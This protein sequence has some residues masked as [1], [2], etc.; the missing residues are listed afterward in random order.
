MW[1]QKPAVGLKEGGDRPALGM[2]E[3]VSSTSQVENR[4]PA[5]TTVD[6]LDN[7]KQ[8]HPPRGHYRTSFDRLPEESTEPVSSAS[9]VENRE[10]ASTNS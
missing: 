7:L 6:T 2:T 10:P 3:P 9:Q 8:V 4:E 5:S 1:W